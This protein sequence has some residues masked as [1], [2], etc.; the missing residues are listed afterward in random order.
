MVQ[1]LSY[2]RNQFFDNALKAIPFESAVNVSTIS[3]TLTTASTAQALLTATAYNFITIYNKNSDTITVGNSST[4][5][6]PI[7]SNGSYSIDVHLAPINLASIY[8]ISATAND[9][10]EVMYA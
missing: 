3:A 6:I 7:T 1:P 9:Y 10:I 8:W 4:Q 2:Y 5:N